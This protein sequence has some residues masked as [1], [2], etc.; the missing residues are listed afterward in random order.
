[1]LILFSF[2]IIF[3]AEEWLSDWIEMRIRSRQKAILMRC[4]SREVPNS[5]SVSKVWGLLACICIR[6]NSDMNQSC[7]QQNINN[8]KNHPHLLLKNYP[9]SVLLISC[10]AQN[11]E[12]KLRDIGD[13]WRTLIGIKFSLNKDTTTLQF[14]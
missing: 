8:V 13:E 1:M 12:Q 10:K 3:N 14:I 5:V 11:K 6:I 2:F 4:F 9:L 7:V